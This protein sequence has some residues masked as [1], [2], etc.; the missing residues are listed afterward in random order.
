MSGSITDV[1]G[2]LVGNHHRIDADATLGSGWAA[3][4]TVVLTPPGTVGAVDVRGGAPGSR[5]TDLLA[6][7]N[8]VRYVD[9]VLLTGGSAYGLAAADGVMRH[10]EEQGRGVAMEGGVVPIVPGAVIFDLPVGGWQCRPTAEFGYAAAATAGTEFA[11][12]TAGAGVGARAGVLKGG[13]GTA[14]VTLPEI[15]VSVGAV[16]AVNA[17]GNVVDPQTGLPWMAHLIREFGL[18][19]PPPEQLA[20]FAE[21]DRESS[22]LNTT[23]AVVAT[24]AAL[25]SAACQRVAIA[26]HDGLAHSIRP[27]H[28]PIDGD[29]VFALATGA[30][31]VQ[32]ASGNASAIP[33]SLSPETKLVAAIGAAAADCL[34][35]AVLSGVLAAESI[36][37]IPTY[38][39]MLPGAFGAEAV[40]GTGA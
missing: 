3:G 34:A 40:T 35:I 17:A 23:I 25:S 29:T 37:G 19:P 16:V 8:S 11:V 1:A 5:E 9:A 15:G 39:G 33:A 36:A 14:S 24:D 13:L 12:G 7:A 18:V 6:P 27:A 22:P 10:L 38:R 30:I 2:I 31:E 26:A 20:A 4:S 28:T 21:L 32:P